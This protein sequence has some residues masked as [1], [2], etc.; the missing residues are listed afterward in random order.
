MKYDDEQLL[1]T[2]CFEESSVS[3]AHDRERSSTGHGVARQSSIHQASSHQHNNLQVNSHK[4]SN[5]EA[6]SN[7]ANN[8]ETNSHATSSH[9]GVKKPRV[10]KVED[11]GVPVYEEVDAENSECGEPP[12]PEFADFN[13][14]RATTTIDSD[15][16]ASMAA[17]FCKVFDGDL[18]QI[19]TM[20][21]RNVITEEVSSRNSFSALPLNVNL[22]NDLR[23][24]GLVYPWSCEMFLF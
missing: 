5:R 12:T 23:C 9:S 6:M 10:M 13:A 8:R 1:L 24:L 16:L 19:P 18:N 22:F 3:T 7:L 15:L 20:T 4:P 21:L 14:R 11:E 17:C 2:I